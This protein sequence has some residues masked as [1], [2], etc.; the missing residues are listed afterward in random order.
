MSKEKNSY[1][2]KALEK[3]FPKEK[4]LYLYKRTPVSLPIWEEVTEI[5]LDI[6]K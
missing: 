4:A 3:D 5:V 2:I 1:S 6:L